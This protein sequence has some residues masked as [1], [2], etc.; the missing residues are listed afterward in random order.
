MNRLRTTAAILLGIVCIAGLLYGVVMTYA[1]RILFDPAVFSTK[2]A[3]SLAEPPVAHVVADQISEQIVSYKRELTPYRPIVLGTVQQIVASPAFRALVRQ[4]A[5]KIHP[6]LI[7]H[8]AD[9]SLTLT[10]VQVIV[11]QALATNPAI[12]AKLPEKAKFVLGSKEGIP[13]GKLLMR[14]IRTGE[15]FQRRAILWLVAGLMLGALGLLAARRKDRYLLGLGI[16]LMASAFLL[17][18][19]ARFGGSILAGFARTPIGSDLVRGLWPVFI[20]P[21]ALRMIILA[22]LGIVLTASV[23]SFLERLDA[24]AALRKVWAMARHRPGHAT[25]MILRGIAMITAGIIV[26]FH[27]VETLEVI[28]VLAGALLLFVGLQDVFVTAARFAASGPAAAKA[29]PRARGAWWLPAGVGMLVVACLVGGA[30]YWLT[31]DP[32]MLQGMGPRAVVAVN[33][34]AELRDRPLNEVVFPTTH[35]SMSALPIPNWMFAEQERTIK[36]QLEDGVRGFLIDVHYGEPVQ[37]RIRTVMT[38]E[39][40]AMKKYEAVLGKEGLEAAMRIRNRLVG[41]PEGEKDVYLAHG[42]CELGATRLVDALSDMKDF[43]RDNSNEVVIIIIQDEGVKPTDVASRFEMSG[44]IDYVYRGPVAPPWPTLGDMVERGERVVVYAEN[45]TTGVPWYH[46]MGGNIQETPY[47]FHSPAEFSNRPNR[48]GTK[49]SLLLMNHWIETAPASKPS[50]AEIVN[51]YGVLLKRA[52]ACRRERKMVPNLVAV[53]FY[54]T[55]DLFR[56]CRALN[57]VPEA[58]ST[59]AAR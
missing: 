23:T 18:A 26:A 55:G 17:A 34:Y 30:V 41:E 47:G 2:V 7:K 13:T 54:R 43:L 19:F 4:A 32:V 16:G 31:R 48:G 51:A 59:V 35:N 44:L 15:R 3:E 24:S 25:P 1:T 57:G 5:L 39:V 38:N 45:D 58:D 8:G 6:L 52:R 42:F 56:V 11:K 14:I 53:D 49:G 28:A 36:D 37:G 20:G 21:L 9:L 10:D 27:P 22:G 40:N 46:L 50:N 29:A 33:G 12:A